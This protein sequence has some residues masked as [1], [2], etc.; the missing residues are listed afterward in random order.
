MPL[1]A[2]QTA[3]L[4]AIQAQVLAGIPDPAERRVLLKEA[5]FIMR[6]DRMAAQVASTTSRTK[7]IEAATPVNV[8]SVLAG[9][10]AS[11]SSGPIKGA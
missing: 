2:E 4:Q 11:L 9:L 7:K 3:R 5:I 8:G 1:S 6:G 10:K